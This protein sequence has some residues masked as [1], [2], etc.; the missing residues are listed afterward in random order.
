MNK[1]QK[2]IRKI[3]FLGLCTAVALLLSYVEALVPPIYAA[4][5]GIKLGLPNIAIIFVLYNFGTRDAAAVSFVRILIV[6]L[7]FG[8]TMTLAYSFAG[9]LLSLAVMS[10]LKKLDFLSGIG[11]SVAGGVCHNLG[12][13]LVAMLLLDTAEIGYYMI[14]LAVTGTISGIFV[15]LCG[16]FIIKRLSTNKLQ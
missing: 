15:G 9:A 7:L 8:N 1:R 5:P 13:V 6:S 11:V 3:A 16:N 4:V 14:I 2:K 10:I 12:Q